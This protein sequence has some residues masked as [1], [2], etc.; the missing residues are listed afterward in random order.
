MATVRP[1]DWRGGLTLRGSWFESHVAHLAQQLQRAGLGLF[2]VHVAVNAQTFGQLAS[3]RENRV[4]RGHRLLKDHAD[5]IAANIAHQILLGLRQI[6][7]I[8]FLAIKN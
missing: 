3:N 5:L 7:A 8:A 1:T 6:D 2:L 4:Q